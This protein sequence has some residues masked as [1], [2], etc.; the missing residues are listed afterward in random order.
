MRVAIVGC[1]NISRAHI[2]ALQTVAGLEICAVCDRDLDR[3]KEAGALAPSARVYVD[4][5]TLLKQERPDAVHVLTPPATHAVLAIQAMQAGCHVLVEKPMAL[6]VQEA[7]LMIAAGRENRVKLCVNHNYL[8]KPS[9]AK[10]RRLVESGAIGQVVY[11]HSFYGLS[12]ETGGYSGGAGRYHWAWR[13][14]GG[15]FTNFLPHLI[16]LQ[17]E[18]LRAVDGVA[19]VSFSHSQGGKALPTEMNILLQGPGASGAMSVSMRA[20]PY[21]KFVEV[22]GTKGIIRADL[23]REVCTIHRE[24]PMPRMLSKAIFNMEDVLQLTSGTLASTTQVALGRMKN[25]PGLHGLIDLFYASIRNDGE[26]PVPGEDGR[27]T[28]QLLEEVWTQSPATPVE[29]SAGS[30]TA[31]PTGPQ[32]D[33]ERV[34]RGRGI[35]GKVL[36]TGATGFLGHRLVGALARCGADVVI[37][38]RDKSQVSPDLERQAEI[39][40]GD[41]RDPASVETAM[42]GV[43]TVYH[44]AAVTANN[45]SW[46]MHHQTNVLGTET[47]LRE[48][49]KA[50][51]QRVVHVSSVIVYGLDRPRD[52][53]AISEA[54]QYVERPDRYAY[55]MRS[56]T[57]AD[58]LALKYWREEGLPVTVLRLGLLYGPGGGYNID[59]G[60]VQLG[61][62]RLTFGRGRN[63]L[64][65]TYVDD[66]VDCLLLAAIAPSA[67]GQ[68]YNVVGESQVCVRDAA[69]QSMEIS[70]EHAALVPVPPFLLSGV[71]GL[72][73]W[74]NGKAGSSVPPRLSRYVVRSACRDIV[75]DTRKAAEQLG[76]QGSVTLENGLQRIHLHHE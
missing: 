31:E 14:P 38:A 33:A 11:V 51:V 71:A 37:L 13:L 22:Y 58:K 7:E 76:W 32:T 41:L 60:L 67:A 70:G 73:E 45:V 17:L 20:K 24:R 68:A 54:H 18:F 53:A 39:V 6:S 25:M 23:V 4:F 28:V 15:V 1:G 21:V 62:V 74:R 19:G 40:S 50:D 16:Y 63:R 5:E 49:L 9:V 65:F 57:E 35:P 61:S 8:F 12:G 27:K 3:A 10:A 47:V 75:Y 69:L 66:A 2:S 26:P 46:E 56:K 29:V 44:C 72:L 36:V 48:A 55:Y 30:L 42:Q 52:A 64:P 43:G 59:R 34:V